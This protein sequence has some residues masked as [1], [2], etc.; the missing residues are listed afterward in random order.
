MPQ[1]PRN[2]SRGARPRCSPSPNKMAYEVLARKWRPARFDQ[3]VGQEAVTRTLSNALVSGRVAHAFLFSGVRGVGKTTT[4]RILAK[5]LNCHQGISAEPCDECVSCTEIAEA[6]SVDVQEVDAASNTGVDN[7]REIRESVRYGT[8]RDRHKIFIIDEVH[9]LSKGAFNALLKTLEE[10][11]PHVKFILCTTEMHRIPVTITSRCQQHDF[12]PIAFATIFERL[13]LICEKEG[14]QISDFGLHAVAEAAKGSMRDAQSVLDK[15]V[16]LGG[17]SVG[18]EDVSALLGLVDEKVLG[19][20]VAAIAERNRE[21]LLARIQQVADEGIGAIELCHKL[22]E[23]VR[24][25]LVAKV[26]GWDTGLIH[27]GESHK[28]EFL[29]QAKLFSRLDLLRFYDLLAQ[30]STDLRL[31]PHPAV[32]LEMALMKLVEL[33]GLP[34]LEEVIGRLNSGS[35][36]PAP[37]VSSVATA[38]SAAAPET[39][40]PVEKKTPAGFAQ[41]RSPEKQAT[42]E[43]PP[44]SKPSGGSLEEQLIARLQQNHVALH[45]LLEHASR[46]GFSP[47]SLKVEFPSTERSFFKMVDTPETRNLLTELCAKIC[48]SEPSVEIS[49]REGSRRKQESDPTEDS[50]VQQFLEVF[51]G[52]ISV[53]RLTKK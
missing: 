22:L 32:H 12:K 13:R 23:H 20:L 17:N 26:A 44:D 21:S 25:L 49:I 4:A 3:V 8:S 24:N 50:K 33:A 51:P 28:D 19:S 11:P 43:A 1:D 36:E 34:E 35:L 27:I 14:V 5:C 53:E 10:P 45:S 9:M 39:S 6:R 29:R 31:H 52:K 2:L 40:V 37:V 46:I 30:V 16:A 18:D 42:R 7:I 48:G 38:K 15:M 41:G 47:E